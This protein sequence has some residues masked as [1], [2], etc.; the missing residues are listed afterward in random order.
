MQIES[1]IPIP[2][3]SER[4]DKWGFANMQIGD[5]MIVLVD[6]QGRRPRAVYAA[7]AHGIAHGKKFASQKHGRKHV[8][9]WRIL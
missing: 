9:I 7:K 2:D 3:A 4:Q 8:R 1:N 6:G 5:E